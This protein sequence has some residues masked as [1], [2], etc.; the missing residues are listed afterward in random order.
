MLK[1]L[2]IIFLKFHLKKKIKKAIQYSY[3]NSNYRII[4]LKI[5]FIINIIKKLLREKKK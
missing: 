4:K 3:L 2:N 5:I 1:E